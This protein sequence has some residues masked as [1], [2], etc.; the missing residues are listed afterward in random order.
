MK[1]ELCMKNVKLEW[2]EFWLL[3]LYNNIELF[4]PL[5]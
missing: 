3:E 1:G 2:W 5:C 4:I